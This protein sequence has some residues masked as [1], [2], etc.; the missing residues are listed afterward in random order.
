M[1]SQEPTDYEIIDNTSVTIRDTLRGPGS[2]DARANYGTITNTINSSTRSGVTTF[3]MSTSDGTTPPEDATGHLT[4]MLEYVGDMV[5]HWQR[6]QT[7]LE[8]IAD[9]M[10]SDSDGDA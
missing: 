2:G 7:K 10:G 3:R 5:A 8:A 6:V 9:T 1:S 4:D